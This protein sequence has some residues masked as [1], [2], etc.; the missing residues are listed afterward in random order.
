[1]Q[2]IYWLYLNGVPINRIATIRTKKKAPAPGGGDRWHWSTVYNILT[3][4][5]YMGDALLQKTY[6]PNFLTHKSMVNNRAIWQYYVE[7]SHPAI[8]D[9][10]TWKLVQKIITAEHKRKTGA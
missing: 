9:K 4:E 1:M 2:R 7:N 5:K 10:E 6:T 3:N 8:V